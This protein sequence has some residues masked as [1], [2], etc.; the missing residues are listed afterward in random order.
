MNPLSKPVVESLVGLI[1]RALELR[2]ME[3]CKLEG[4]AVSEGMPWI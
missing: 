3:V 4:K 1:F 2:E